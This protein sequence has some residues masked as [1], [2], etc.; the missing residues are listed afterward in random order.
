M[1]MGPFELVD[2]VG[3]DTLNNVL[4]NCYEKCQEEKFKPI[5]LVQKL[6]SEGKL[7]KKSGEGFYKYNVE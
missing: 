2:L 4:S 1:R 3:L 7:G 5:E 6:I